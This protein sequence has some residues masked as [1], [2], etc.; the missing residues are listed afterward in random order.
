M[1]TTYLLPAV[2]S[3]GDGNDLVIPNV[4][5]HERGGP[6]DGGC[7]YTA[8]AALPGGGAVPEL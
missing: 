3:R 7:A 2:T 5:G 6:E 4:A 1:M 8:P